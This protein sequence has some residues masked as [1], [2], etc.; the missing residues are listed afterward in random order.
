MVSTRSSNQG[1]KGAGGQYDIRKKWEE[2]PQYITEIG[3]TLH[4]YQLEGVNWLRHCWSQGIDAILADEM[5]LGKTIQALTL[6]YSLMKEGH[7]QGPFLIAAPLSTVINWKREAELWCPDFTVLTYT[8]DK[9]SRHEIQQRELL[10]QKNRRGYRSKKTTD[11]LEFHVLL[12]SYE[13]IYLDKR[14]L[15]HIDWA[16]IVIDEAHRLKNNRSLFFKTLSGYKLGYR[17]LLTGTPLQN[18][19]EELFNLLNFLSPDRF[20]DLDAFTKEFAEI[21]NEDQ[22]QKLHSL[23]GSR[24]LR[25][26]KADVF[27][28]IPPKKELIVRVDLTP[29]QKH[30]YKAILTRNYAALHSTTH[31]GS[32]MSLRNILMDLR[33]CCNHPYLLPKAQDEAPTLPNGYYEGSAMIKACGK[34]ALL[35]KMLAKL[36]KGGHR[37]LIFS[38]MTQ[39]L[40]I[41]EDLCVS[42]GYEFERIDGN[43]PGE[44]RQEAIDRFNAPHSEQFIFLLS[45]RAG[46]L[47]I[48]LATADT[49]IIYDSDWNPHNDIQALSRC[50][51]IGQRKP[52]M[53]YRFV[54]RN[55]VEERMASVAKKKMLLTHL[56][57]RSGIGQKVASITK[58]ELEDVLRWGTE[59]LFKEDEVSFDE[60]GDRKTGIQKIHWD[61]EAV[62]ALLSQRESLEGEKPL[63]SSDSQDRNWAN[64]Y[65]SS[66][67]VAQYTIC[68]EDEEEELV[69]EPVQ[70]QDPHYW[71]NL[72]DSHD[73]Q[74]P[75]LGKGH[76]LRK[77]TSQIF[78]SSEKA[79]KS[80]PSLISLI[81]APVETSIPRLFASR[82]GIRQFQSGAL[83]SAAAVV[84]NGNEASPDSSSSD[85]CLV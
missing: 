36:K 37:V 84:P 24:M 25:R 78:L 35:Q 70:E 76:R 29:M 41:L 39:L 5:G 11:A 22:I 47:G 51:R 15:A 73:K 61:D 71:K 19:L 80:K 26:L 27:A 18:N 32:K 52:V 9:N 57:I 1:L 16:A 46:G 54:C 75:E 77:R 81:K 40:N 66:F 53:I 8:G 13:L 83:T 65:L 21:S 63:D 20:D 72:L 2:Q 74:E 7:S 67:K 56:V 59:A 64:E 12:T 44:E 68:G 45:T 50:H 58:A 49:V 33:K 42:E 38:Q 85:I 43:V 82:E 10:F 60:S 34:F 17:M 4:P 31:V 69:N 48:N 3:A 14:Y 28:A 30:F 62:N 79:K 6:L 23:L 55:T